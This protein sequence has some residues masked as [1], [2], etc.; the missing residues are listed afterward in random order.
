MEASRRWSRHEVESVRVTFVPLTAAHSVRRSE[1]NLHFH[2]ENIVQFFNPLL[3]V[4]WDFVSN[5]QITAPILIEV[6]QS[7]HLQKAYSGTQKTD[8]HGEALSSS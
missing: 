3:E 7:Y 8:P 2:P 5:A 4:V 6:N 1:S